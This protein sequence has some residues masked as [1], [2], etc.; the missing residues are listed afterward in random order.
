MTHSRG[1]VAQRLPRAPVL[2]VEI[3]AAPLEHILGAVLEVL[4]QDSR[5]ALYLCP[6]SVHG[7][8]E[9]QKDSAFKRLLNNAS[10][11]VPDGMPL[12]RSAQWMGNRNAERAFGPDV[13][14]SVLERTAGIG[15]KHFFYGGREGVADA[16]ASEMIRAFPGLQVA[17]TYCPPFRP[18]TTDEEHE[19]ASLINNS[20]ADVVWVGLSTPKQERWIGSMRERLDVKLLCSVGAAFDY[21][22][23]SIEGAPGW[24][25]AASLEWL[26]RLVQEPRRLWR[27][28]GEIV[29]TFLLLI[30]LQFLGLKK[31]PVTDVNQKDAETA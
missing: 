3:V 26:Y 5:D 6:T 8:I 15:T 23:G 25:K 7:V 9:A 1:S 2:G 31:F 30:T 29:P 11:N 16:L 28:Y 10:F 17:G 18:L 19:V 27:R 12:V 4:D 22:T 20:G 24:M 14:L 21:H 13:M